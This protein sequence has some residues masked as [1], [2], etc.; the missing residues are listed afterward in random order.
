MKVSKLFHWLYALLM[1]LPA[2]FVGGRMAYTIFNKNAKDSYSGAN[3]YSIQYKYETNEIE[4]LEDLK[5]GN[6]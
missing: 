6:I 3:G 1:L 2:F 4:T 5:T